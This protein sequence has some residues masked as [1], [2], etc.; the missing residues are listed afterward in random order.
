MEC[1]KIQDELS[2]LLDGELGADD[3]AMLEAHLAECDACRQA[4]EKMKHVDSLYRSLVPQTA[5]EGFEASVRAAIAVPCEDRQPVLQPTWRR[6]STWIAVAACVAVIVSIGVLNAGLRSERFDVA[7]VEKTTAP[8]PQGVVDE[9]VRDTGALKSAPETLNPATPQSVS[10]ESANEPQDISKKGFAAEVPVVSDKESMPPKR[11]PSPAGPAVKKDMTQREIGI[12]SEGGSEPIL[13][14][15]PPSA[16][17]V[18]PVQE[19]ANR[20]QNEVSVP[21]SSPAA[22][23]ELEPRMAERAALPPPPPSQAK[24]L[25]EHAT[26]HDATTTLP[27]S[28]ERDLKDTDSVGRIPAAPPV[29]A[30]SKSEMMLDG[31][32]SDAGNPASKKAEPKPSARKSVADRTF[33]FSNGVWQQEGYSK[34]EAVRTLR[35]GSRTLDTFLKKHPDLKPLLTLGDHVIFQCDQRWYRLEPKSQ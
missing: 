14:S 12:H 33:T 1:N 3:Q 8:A 7:S 29:A 9:N 31:M 30:E 6:W 2:T 17:G 32:A 22:T 5:P 11:E 28:I 23:Q 24:K 10:R 20:A 16:A 4:L 13:L 18:K 25:E 27:G 19:G 34:G 21:P 15:T 26:T 35:R